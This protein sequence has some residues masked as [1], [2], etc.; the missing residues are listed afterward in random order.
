MD[1]RT[2]MQ[3]AFD[4][5]LAVQKELAAIT[6]SQMKL[7]QAQ[8]TSGFDAWRNGFAATHSAAMAMSKVY[9]DALKAPAAA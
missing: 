6:E 5:N 4:T 8:L 3:T 7:A 2:Q 9:A 1:F